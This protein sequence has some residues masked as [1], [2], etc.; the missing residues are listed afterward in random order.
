MTDFEEDPLEP[1]EDDPTVMSPDESGLKRWILLRG[2]RIHVTVALLAAVF[3]VLLVSSVTWSVGMRD[4]LTETDTIQTLFN[5]LLSGTIL[6]VSIIVSI[7]SI[8][9]AQDITSLGTQKDR[10]ENV[11]EYRDE[12]EDLAEVFDTSTDP[13]AYLTTELE[14][15]LDRVDR[16]SELLDED[17]ET[18]HEIIDDYISVVSTH[19]EWVI[20]T[21]SERSHD[22]SNVL[23]A[24]LSYDYS[25][26][27]NA[28]RQLLRTQGETMSED[29][30][31]ALEDIVEAL[32]LFAVGHE[33]IKTLFYMREFARFSKVLLYVSLP[34]IVFV[35]YVLLGVQ[36]GQFP[37]VTFVGLSPLSTFLI[38]AYTVALTPYV[39][40]TSFVLRTATVANRTLATGPF[41]LD[42]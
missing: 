35:S 3:L 29:Q 39:V 21:L 22:S 42:K 16:L 34:T 14:M 28:A 41:T 2:N 20:S 27:M 36:A 11:V 12:V 19:T 32:E 9:L 26:Q 33:Y 40:L 4:L 18:A 38:G 10:I 31:D 37:D 30:R 17:D 25:R 8:V 13:G 6:L 7:N 1:I 23:L 15:I 5:T 24:G